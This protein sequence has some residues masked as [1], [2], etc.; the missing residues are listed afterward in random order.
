MR[1]L[2]PL[3]GRVKFTVLITSFEIMLSDFAEFR[4]VCA[5]LPTVHPAGTGN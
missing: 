4:S 3:K 2:Q 5:Q 1:P